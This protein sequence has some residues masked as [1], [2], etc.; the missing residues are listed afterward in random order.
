MKIESVEVIPM[1][2][3]S[4]WVDVETP[5]EV[6]FITTSFDEW[7]TNTLEHGEKPD[8]ECLAFARAQ[9][10]FMLAPT[11]LFGQS[12]YVVKARMSET[13]DGL[14][15]PG[16]LYRISKTEIDDMDSEKNVY[17]KYVDPTSFEPK[18]GFWHSK[19]TVYKLRY[20]ILQ[21]KGK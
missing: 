9:K 12:L 14:V 8:G 5:F 3:E 16:I 20:G 17:R 21:E 6:A 15:L 1:S 11:G 10:A 13:L 4:K 19:K 18:E 2:K 7:Y